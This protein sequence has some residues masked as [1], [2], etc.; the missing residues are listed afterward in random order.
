L[1]NHFTKEERLHSK[2]LVDELFARGSSFFL[3]PFKVIYAFEDRDHNVPVRLLV[4][5][6]K[7]H[8]KR[9]VDRNRLKRLVRESYR[10]H[11][12]TL[13]AHL[14]KHSK[15]LNFGLVY[16]G[17]TILSHAEIERKLILILQRIIEQDEESIR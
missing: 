8:F 7:R 10:L 6:S 9:A 2:K 12:D 14:E 3:Y 5:V 16:V 11:K 17:E 4:T 13:F 15:K 1:S